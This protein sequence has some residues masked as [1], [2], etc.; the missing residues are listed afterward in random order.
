MSNNVMNIKELQIL[1]AAIAVFARHGYHKSTISRI[2]EEAGIATG[3]IYLYFKRKEDLIVALFE[4]I[5][6][7]YIRDARPAVM[8]STEPAVRL[9]KLIELHFRFFE[10]DHAVAAA[11]QIHLRE[12]NPEIRQ[13]IVPVLRRY[14]DLIDQIISEGKAQRAIGEEIDTR[15]AR[16]LIFGGLDA[17]VTSWVLSGHKYSLM[18]MHRDFHRMII[19]ALGVRLSGADRHPP[20]GG[21][22]HV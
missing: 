15:L 4:Q 20:A 5:L 11:F 8:E 17:I 12:V 1:R 2:A 18:S 9:E 7:D 13:G 3:T 16:K 19:R 6:G 14:F 10:G 22:F 21:D